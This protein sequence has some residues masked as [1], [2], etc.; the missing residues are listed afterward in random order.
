L[1]QIGM[2][3]PDE[4]SVLE[5]AIATTRLNNVEVI[6][7]DVRRRVDFEAVIVLVGVHR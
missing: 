6:G 3:N 4:L 2:A 7:V 5:N 1:N